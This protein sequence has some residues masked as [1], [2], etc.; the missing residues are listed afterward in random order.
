MNHPGRMGRR[1]VKRLLGGGSDHKPEPVLSDFPRQTAPVE[2]E[3]IQT[4]GVPNKIVHSNFFVEISIMKVKI[5]RFFMI[6]SF[7]TKMF[8]TKRLFA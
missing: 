2:K 3:L 1:F 8:A 5:M 6:F 4:Q 7:W